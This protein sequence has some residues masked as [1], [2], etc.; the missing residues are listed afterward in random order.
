M[1]RFETEFTNIMLNEKN[2]FSNFALAALLGASP[3]AGVAAYQHL[4]PK[5]D[6]T[7]SLSQP[8]GNI[9]Q[10]AGVKHDEATLK[11]KNIIARTLWAEAREDGA[12]G[13]KGVASVVFNRAK[14]KKENILPV[15]SRRKQFSC[16]NAMTEQDWNNFKMKE[17]TGPIWSEANRIAEEMVTGSFVPSTKANHYFNPNKCS[18]AW[19]LFPDGTERPYSEIGSHR[20]LVI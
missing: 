11:L 6:I 3:L 19:R 20:F 2:A 9:K 18:P 16:W 8:I 15:I 12:N 7:Q 13:M 17:K 4:K 1:K 5:T 10:V 14:G